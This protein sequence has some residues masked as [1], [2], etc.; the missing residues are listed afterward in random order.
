MNQ[1]LNLILE[2]CPRAV[3][4]PNKDSN[5]CAAYPNYRHTN[6]KAPRISIYK[7]Y[8]NMTR[9]FQLSLARGLDFLGSILT[10]FVLVIF[11]AATDT[12]R[13]SFNS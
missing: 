11:R 1:L 9:R 4:H 13:R 12:L 6:Y 2:S 5:A 7:R 3:S 8:R 10:P